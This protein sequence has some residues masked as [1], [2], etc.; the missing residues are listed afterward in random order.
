MADK[1]I[2]LNDAEE[3]E[4]NFS[5]EQSQDIAGDALDDFLE[6][7]TQDSEQPE[8]IKTT[9]TPPKPKTTNTDKTPK[10]NTPS[11]EELKL[12]KEAEEKEK[13]FQEFLEED[14]TPDL[15]NPDPKENDNKDLDD[16]EDPE[17]EEEGI[18]S[19]S[20]DLYK[21]GFFVKRDENE[22]EPSTTEEL[23]Q[24]LNEEKQIGAEE[25][26]D[27][28]AGKHGE[29]WREAFYAMFVDGVHPSEYIAKTLEVQE[30]ANMDLTDEDNQVRVVREGLKRQHWEDA[31]I[32]DEIKRLKTN[33][34]LES[35][36]AKY[37]KALVKVEE[38][39]KVQL[40]EK[41]KQETARSE[42]LDKIYLTN[43]NNYLGKAV[44]EKEFDG[45]PVTK[46]LAQKA[47][48]MAYQKKWT[49]PK[50]K[51]EITDLDRI[52]LDL[53]KP[54]NH[55]LKAKIALL[56]AQ[57]FNGFEA[58]S[59]LNL[60]LSKIQKKA[61]STEKTELFNTLTRNKKQASTKGTGT[62]NNL[63]F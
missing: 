10:I 17:T 35:V 50:T 27:E 3:L 42:Q 53:R 12:R 11:E 7:N 28:L 31:D 8:P 37:H 59:K 41:A 33:S 19:F 13:G 38:Q 63:A 47:F 9:Q 36:S 21:M 56:F 6:G 57:T 26:V 44:K 16:D 60:D 29:E 5:M 40:A 58:G 34:D 48:N 54:E 4:L 30:F 62:K 22:V 43:L 14:E 52:F 24:K 45:I 2:D 32:N 49:L 15:S 20:K 55:A 61:L 1:N 25:L 46:D 23:I 51:E 18:K 39:E